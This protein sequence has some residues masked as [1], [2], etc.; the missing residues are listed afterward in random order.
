MKV[1]IVVPI[2]NEEGNLHELFA[3]LFKLKNNLKYTIEIV[4]V[5][6]NSSDNS[7]KIITNFIKNNDF[8]T[9]VTRNK[10][11]NGMGF[12]LIE[13]TKK[14]KGDIIVWVMA[15]NSDD[16]S[17]IQNMLEKIEQG[18]DMVF[19]SRY[20]KGG[21][22]GDLDPVKA[23]CSSGYT[24]LAKLIYG[25]KVHD[26]TNAFRCF[27]KKVF[28]EISLESGDF[29][30]SPEF[31]IKAHMKKFKLGEVPTG[32]TNRKAG[33]TK[34]KM[35]KMGKRYLGLLKYRFTYKN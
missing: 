6:D 19:G 15:D 30:I 26:I 16:F 27:R 2:Y 3:S 23:I 24:R 1:S 33:Q 11:N 29:A 13:G 7:E 4:A 34:F 35:I 12:A 9:L 10:G 25:I 5:N 20:T 28:D 32:Y 21:S 17:T 14:A 22:R 8:I 18:Y 31:A